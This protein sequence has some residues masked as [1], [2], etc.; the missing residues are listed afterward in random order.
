M[1]CPARC[2]PSISTHQ[3]QEAE[4]NSHLDSLA[5][6]VS[7]SEAL[8]SGPSF[9]RLVTADGALIPPVRVVLGGLAGAG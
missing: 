6:V 1:K 8:E 4:K 5:G 9:P 7:I 2:C 3:R